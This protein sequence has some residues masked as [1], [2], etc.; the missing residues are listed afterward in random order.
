MAQEQYLNAL[1]DFYNETRRQVLAVTGFNHDLRE[2]DDNFNKRNRFSRNLL[3]PKSHVRTLVWYFVLPATSLVLFILMLLGMLI[4]AV[5]CSKRSSA[6]SD[7]EVK[8]KTD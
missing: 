4:D 3:L 6:T 1:F 2:Y 5:I 7:S 8:D